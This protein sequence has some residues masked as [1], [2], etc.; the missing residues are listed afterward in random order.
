MQKKWS[1]IYND[2]KE[3]KVMYMKSDSERSEKYHWHQLVDGF[4]FDRAN[5][6]THAQ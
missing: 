2:Y 1:A 3:D 4:M 5:V 6:V